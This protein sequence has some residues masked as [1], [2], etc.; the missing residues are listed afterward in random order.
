[1]VPSEHAAPSR[2][3]D[4]AFRAA[5]K[6]FPCPLP[7]T[8]LQIDSSA[9]LLRSHRPSQ[10][11]T[12]ETWINFPRRAQL[13]APV[14]LRVHFRYSSNNCLRSSGGR[15]GNPAG[16]LA[17]KNSSKALCTEAVCSSKV[18]SSQ[19]F[20]AGKRDHLP[21]V[22]AKFT[23]PHFGCRRGLASSGSAPKNAGTNLAI[24]PL[25]SSDFAVLFATSTEPTDTVSIVCSSGISA[26]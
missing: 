3:G 15:A 12:V 21:S 22:A 6:A 24:L 4:R 25:D 19:S 18:L 13:E 8:V 10:Q 2:E 20:A 14:A 26:G 9:T 5:R 1:M 7:G 17:R 23:S 11:V 16:P